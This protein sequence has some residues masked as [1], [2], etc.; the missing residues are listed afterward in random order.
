MVEGSGDFSIGSQVWPGLSKL[1]EEMGE[2]QQVGGKLIAIRGNADHW[3]GTDL[4]ERLI[5]EMADVKAALEFFQAQNFTAKDDD[6][7]KARME[8]KSRLFSEWHQ[9]GSN[10]KETKHDPPDV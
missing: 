3:D 8:A 1:L 5:E 2:L 4:R 7:I 9:N 6:R 10:K